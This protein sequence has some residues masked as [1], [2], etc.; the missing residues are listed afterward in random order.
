MVKRLLL[1]L[2]LLAVVLGGVFAFKLFQLK[3]MQAQFAQPLP[4]SPIAAT[5]ARQEQWQPRLPAAGSLVAVNG[6]E[7]TTEI[8]GI[9]KAIHFESGQPVKAGTVLIELEDSVDR[10]ALEG[11]RAERRLA[12][13]K[14]NRAMDLIKRSAISK[15]EFDETQANADAAQ[16]RVAEKAA[17]LAQKTIRAPFDGLIGI[18]Q[19]NLGQYLA[20][21]SRI[22]SLQAL[23]PIYADYALPERH[24][25]QLSVGQ[26]VELKVA[27]YPGRVFTGTVSA[28]ASAVESGSRSLSVRATL[29]NGEAL[30]RPGMFA[31]VATLQAESQNVITVPQTAVSFN[32]YGN[33]VYVIIQG[34][35]TGL[36]VKRRQV[37]TGRVRAGQVEVTEG[38]SIGEQ[39][40]RAGL[41]KL[42]D[43]QAVVIDNSVVLDDTK[44]GKQ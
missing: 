38:L 11:A 4:P 1:V 19:V 39:V 22:V 17:K 8:G 42:R 21:G 25:P 13:I 37:T 28:L 23:N 34:E 44:V 41:V 24:L 40:V 43:G 10:A 31:E 32:T 27:A 5:H 16:A 14:L 18:R 36:L 26:S 35:G 29:D 7:V 15:S 2:L 6:T 30:L 20:P 9:V 33:F 12:E 3:M